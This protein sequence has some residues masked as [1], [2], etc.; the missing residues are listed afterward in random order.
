MNLQIKTSCRSGKRAGSLNC[1]RKRSPHPAKKLEEILP[2]RGAGAPG[3]LWGTIPTLDHFMKVG[4]GG[5][6]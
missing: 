3:A 6:K 4:K 1:S 2:G 5:A